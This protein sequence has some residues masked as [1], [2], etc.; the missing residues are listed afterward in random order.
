MDT[1]LLKQ[2]GNID[3][4]AGVREA[5]LSCGRGRG[6]RVAEL[7]NAAGLRFTVCP[8]RGMD[9]L[10]LSYRGV[11][12]SFR[13]KNGTVGPAYVS[14]LPK[15]FAGQ[16]PGGMLATCGLD[17]VGGG[18]TDGEIFPTHGRISAL[19]ADHFGASAEWKGNDYVLRAEG[20][21]HQSGL[22]GRNLVLRREIATSLNS[23]SLTIHD[24]LTNMEPED[25]PFMLLY[26][27]NF[28]YPLLTPESLVYTSPTDIEPR[29]D[30]S[31]DNHHMMAPVD[32]RGEELY[33]H[34]PKTKTAWGA[35]VNPALGL[36]GYVRFDSA[37]L[38]HF[39]QWKN[40]R[41]HDYVLAIEP[42]NCRGEGRLS[43][44]NKGIISVI[45]GYASLEYTVEIGALDGEKEIGAFLAQ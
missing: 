21:M 34:T 6:L 17:N 26:H 45:K 16:W 2:L 33:L 39:L 36:G 10:D 40:M 35:L 32:G 12:Y 19:P 41:S 25:E 43:E 5:E 37:N 14:P 28:G 29:N 3:Q 18:S 13:T 20:E 9:I 42:C 8:D 30:I 1:K 31:H 44:L 22:C 4:I 23:R 7:Y 27:C 24:T 15:E 38:P 11:N